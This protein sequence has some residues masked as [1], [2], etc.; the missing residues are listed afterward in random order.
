MTEI[1]RFDPLNNDVAFLVDRLSLLPE[2]NALLRSMELRAQ[3][4]GRLASE[5]VNQD[6][7][8][9]LINGV[10]SIDESINRMFR[11]QAALT[12]AVELVRNEIKSTKI[13]K[14]KQ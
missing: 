10:R 8:A 6:P 13:S 11:E 5:A 3:E 9:I 7:H 12:V 4:I 2:F 14:L 1:S